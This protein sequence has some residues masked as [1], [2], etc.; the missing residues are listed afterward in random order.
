MQVGGGVACV[1]LTVSDTAAVGGRLAVAGAT[2]LAN[3]L[4]VEGTTALKRAVTITA[5]TS[6]AV[7]DAP[8]VRALTLTGGSRASP[9][10]DRGALK[11]KDGD[12]DLTGAFT[13]LGDTNLAG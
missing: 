6:I 10:D 5:P 1:N 11:V 9:T 12:V 2:T 7:A 3:S 4:V 13:V 8:N